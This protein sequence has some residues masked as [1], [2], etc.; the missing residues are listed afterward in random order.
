MI[1][2]STCT[3][4]M[5]M[6]HLQG[7]HT[8]FRLQGEQGYYA[9]YVILALLIWV[10]TCWSRDFYVDPQKGNDSD[11]GSLSQPFATIERAKQKIRTLIANGYDTHS[12]VYL[13]E[14]I[15]PITSTL[16]FTS[17]DSGTTEFSI[18]YRAYPGEQVRILGGVALRPIDFDLV[19]QN[20]VSTDVWERL[21]PR[22]RGRVR[23][24]DLTEPPYN[25]A[26]GGRYGTHHDKGIFETN[27]PASLELFC[28]SRRMRLAR[29]PDVNEQV[30]EDAFVFNTGDMNPDVSGTYTKQP[31]QHNGRPYY[32]RIIEGIP[33]YLYY[34]FDGNTD[35]W[36]VGPH[37]GFGDSDYNASNEA[38]YRSPERTYYLWLGEQYDS[39]GQ[40]TG[41]ALARI[42]DNAFPGYKSVL[43]DAGD[44]VHFTYEGIRA[45][46]WHR[47]DDIVLSG[48]F[49]NGWAHRRCKPVSLQVAAGNTNVNLPD[50]GNH[51]Y[52]I[53][54]GSKFHVENLLEEI[55]EENEYYLDS[56]SGHLYF[57][58][59]DDDIEREIYVSLMEDYLVSFKGVRHVTFDGILFEMSRGG[60]VY[61]DDCDHVTLTNCTL[62]NCGTNA[63]VIDYNSTSCGISHSKISE[64]GEAAVYL[65]GGNRLTLTS[66]NNYVRGCD[67]ERW[68]AIVK[69]TPAIGLYTSEPLDGH[70]GGEYSCGNQVVHNLIHD[71]PYIA[72]RFRGNNH[73]I[74]YNEIH[75]VCQET[76]DTGA[77]YA[78]NGL[79]ERG[80]IIQYNFLHHL[81]YYED[82][83]RPVFRTS[84]VHGVYLDDF[85]SGISVT[86]NVIYKVA[87]NSILNGG[88]RDNQYVGNIICRCGA[89]VFTDR[90]GNAI[91]QDKNVLA[92]I[93]FYKSREDPWASAYPSLAMFPRDQSYAELRAGG[94]LEPYSI[95][96]GNVCWANQ[97]YM[98]LGYWGGYGDGFDYWQIAPEEGNNLND[99]NPLFMDESDLDLRLRPDSPAWNLPGFKEIPF[100]VIGIEKNQQEESYIEN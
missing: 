4:K 22:C 63:L 39:C 15:Y 10:G 30:S 29:W 81:Q 57:W 82:V 58:P 28:D 36:F 65:D 94:W 44:N 5:A 8:R 21:H 16:Q 42:K 48:F 77:I 50:P 60:L 25:V 84:K 99:Q 46:N 27:I 69:S 52:K 7:S 96:N 2:I 33:W 87:G 12:T 78:G 70:N 93:N 37:L 1:K 71:G 68:G 14:G 43:S 59:P 100:D 19:R 26:I 31:E 23:K 74:R 76:N 92:R 24:I 41:Y 18:V 55:T 95:F 64:T 97:F 3:E 88:G 66:A 73:E 56:R 72:I 75:H 49:G 67:I 20:N 6:M 45:L 90:R 40:A 91:A 51:N 86:G 13:R 79:D 89:A 9:I 61:I 53:N 80:T 38:W 62:R 32:V 83:S 34:K 85:Q 11:N 35:R 54:V 98:R 47:T 17:K